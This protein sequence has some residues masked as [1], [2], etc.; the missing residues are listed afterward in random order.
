MH[1]VKGES[2][3]PETLPL[4]SEGYLKNSKELDLR[5]KKKKKNNKHF[6]GVNILEKEV[7]KLNLHLPY[8]GRI[9][10][11]TLKCQRSSL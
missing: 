3:Q 6:L 11:I 8:G 9:S 5:P 1:E 10:Q 7:E 2:Q 4:I